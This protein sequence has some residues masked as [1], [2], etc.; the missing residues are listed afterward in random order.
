[1]MN[2]DSDQ[3]EAMLS[4]V[5]EGIDALDEGAQNNFIGYPRSERNR[6]ALLMEL[7]ERLLCA[8]EVHISVPKRIDV[9]ADD[10]LGG[11]RQRM[12]RVAAITESCNEDTP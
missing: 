5:R 7:E 12:A 11:L 10:G 4:F 6:W 1:M 3:I 8:E 9:F 2:L